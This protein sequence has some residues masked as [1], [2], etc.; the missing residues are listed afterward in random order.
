MVKEKIP[1]TKESNIGLFDS[2]I[3]IFLLV[4]LLYIN[5]NIYGDSSLEGSNQFVLLIGSAIAFIVG[6]KNKISVEIIFETIGRNIKSI[7]TPIIILLL[8]GA[9]SGSWLISGIIPS[10]IY[11]GFKI[12]NASFFLP[13]CVILSAIVALATGSSWSTS[14]TIGIALIG[15]GKALGFDVGI[16]AGA[17]ISGAYFGD[18]M[19]PLSDTTNLAAAVSGS[20]LFDHIKYMIIT[21]VP[22][23][24]ITI[25]FFTIFNLF[26]LPTDNLNQVKYIESINDYF[27]ISP[28]L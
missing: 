7:S 5:V 24:L 22:T 13:S 15:I 12:I 21:T 2:I 3:P 16:I 20:Y 23:I 9:L 27:Y 19:S 6:F 26:N 4:T 8:V 11:Y 14:A 25:V 17:V 1:Q 10:M 18:K 28:V